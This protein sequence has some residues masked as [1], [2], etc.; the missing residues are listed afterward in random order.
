MIVRSSYKLLLPHLKNRQVTV[1]TGMRRV[2][3]S[4]A[5]QYLLQQIPHTNKIYIDCERIEIRELLNRKNYQSILDELT[6]LGLDFSNPCVIAL[7][8]IQLVQNLPSF[9]KYVY[10]TYKVK[11]IV[12]GSSSYYMKN[13]FSESLAG[14]KRIFEMYPLN[15]L[16]FIQFKKSKILNHEKFS[17]QKFSTAWY[18]QM[19][20]LYEEYMRFGGFPEV[21]LQ[22]KI[23][24][25]RALLKDIINSYIELDIKLLS[26]YSAGE[27]LYKLIKLLAARVGS[28]IDYVKLSSISGISRQKLTNYIALLEH[29]YFI[30]LIRPYTKNID[31]EISS[32]PKLYFSDTGILNELAGIQISSG[33]LFE[34]AI[35]VQLYPMGELQY[36]QKKNGQEID[37]IFKKNTALEVKESAILQDDKILQQRATA[38][39]IRKK[40]LVGRYASKSDFE[41]FVWGGNIF[42][43]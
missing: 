15:F 3:K 21:V 17:W 24:D 18:N 16:E 23:S 2:G 11:F 1:I 6:L 25:K 8:E 43:V 40:I 20:E 31:R 14:R 32:Q 27:E 34:N 33:Q 29:T 30:Y 36:Y 22:K 5:V 7:D 9:I 26:D 10:D 37:F 12:T 41:N 28:K 19:K 4:T 42:E 13:L 38:L 39:G 35:G